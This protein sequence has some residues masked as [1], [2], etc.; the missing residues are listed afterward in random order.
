MYINTFNAAMQKRFGKKMYRLSLDYNFGCPNRDGAVGVGGCVFCS[1]PGAGNFAGRGETLDEK[2]T[3]AKEKIAA[4]AGGDC[5]YIAYF[6]SY[7]NTYA[8]IETLREIFTQAA[9]HPAVDALS[10]ATRPDCL[11]PETLALLAEIN[12]KK[13]IWVELGLQTANEATAAYINRCY[14]LPVYDAA[15]REL[16]ARG[17]EVVTHMILGL[18]RETEEDML[19][20]ARHIAAVG[21][22]GIKLQLLHVLKNTRLAEDFAKGAFDVLS[23][24]AYADILCAI[25]PTLPR[26]MVIHRYTG[27]G[28]KRELIAPL[29]SGDKKRTLNYINRILKERDITQGS[30]VQGEANAEG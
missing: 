11:P 30:A 24:E 9:E 25:L 27:D 21:S 1:Q 26:D 7:T 28:D 23:M 6:Q 3:A 8:P 10:I 18:P 22:E 13:P 15:V 20:T 19:H 17:V 12:R 16:H 14:P 5:G 2:L 29:W 4:K